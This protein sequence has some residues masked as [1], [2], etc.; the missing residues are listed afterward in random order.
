MKKTKRKPATK[1]AARK[2]KRNP[3]RRNKRPKPAA[4][5]STA[6]KA[7]KARKLKRNPPA[8]R[9][10]RKAASHSRS[11]PKP[12]YVR[13]NGR[14]RNGATGADRMFEKFHGRASTKT[15]TVVEKASYRSDLAQLGGLRSLTILTPMGKQVVVNWTAKSPQLCVTPDGKQLY[16]KGGDQKIN[17]SRFG[18]GAP[19]WQ[20]DSMDLGH[21]LKVT[22]RTQKDFHKFETID[23]FH[24]LG[25][26]TGALPS[27]QYD[28]LN[29]TLRISGGQYDVRREGIVN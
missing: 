16:I 6:K 18:M 17:L 26:E 29:G 13:R 19:S 10:A 25:E 22:Y 24:A 7:K 27:V 2:P 9:K 5:K 8:P 14:R 20:K 3:P 28:T 1:K 11:R 4:K 21:L 23:Y 12:K 15:T